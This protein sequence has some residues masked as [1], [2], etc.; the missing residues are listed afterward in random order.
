MRLKHNKT[1]I[2]GKPGV[3][4][5]TFIQKVVSRM[6]DDVRA[7]GFYTSEIRSKGSRLGFELRGLNGVRRTLAHVDFDSRDRVSKY[8]VDTAGFEEFLRKLDLM[9]PDVELIVIDEIAKMELFSNFFRALVREAF[10][11]D[12]CILASIALKGEGLIREIKERT[13][14]HL[15]EVT[16]SN[17]EQLL[18]EVVSS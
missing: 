7:A 16:R 4:K 5:T 18:E 15:F 2:T 14:V 8:G 12:K 9:N 13:D 1:L 10:D 6:G 17:R 11:S 3:G